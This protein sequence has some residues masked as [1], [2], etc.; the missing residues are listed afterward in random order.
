MAGRGGFKYFDSKRL[1]AVDKTYKSLESHKRA[2]KMTNET[3]KKLYQLWVIFK[4]SRKIK[5]YKIYNSFSV[6]SIKSTK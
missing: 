1:Q 6:L 2:E 5:Q 3:V 4:T